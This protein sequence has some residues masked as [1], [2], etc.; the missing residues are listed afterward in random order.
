MTTLELYVSVKNGEMTFEDFKKNI[1]LLKEPLEKD[2]RIRE[3][4]FRVKVMEK[5]GVHPKQMLVEFIDYWTEAN[6]PTSKMR[7]EKEKTFNLDKRLARWAKNNQ[8]KKGYA[9]PARKEVDLL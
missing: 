9:M 7:F 8:G 4:K 3:N 6:N 5:S 1:P 2:Q